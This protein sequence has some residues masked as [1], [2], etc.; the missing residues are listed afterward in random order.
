MAIV[1]GSNAPPP[2]PWIARPA[3]IPG[4][5]AANAQTIDP[6]RKSASDA[7]NASVRPTISESLPTTGMATT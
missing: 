4:R 7:W 2:A 3:T 6:T 1:T 5:S